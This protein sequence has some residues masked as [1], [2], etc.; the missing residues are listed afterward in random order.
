M[1]AENSI[2]SPPTY[3]IKC[4]N[5]IVSIR[6]TLDFHFIIWPLL[7]KCFGKHSYAQNQS[8]LLSLHTCVQSLG[9]VE[10]HHSAVTGSIVTLT[11]QS[12]I[13]NISL[14]LHE[15]KCLVTSDIKSFRTVTVNWEKLRVPSAIQILWS[16]QKQVDNDPHH[17]S[18]CCKGN[19]IHPTWPVQAWR[20]SEENLT[21]R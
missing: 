2:Q 19:A 14:L 15:Q 6:C 20:I 10:R 21:S 9:S 5:Y 7:Y 12:V 13:Q 18:Y 11:S 1:I 3:Y 16:V 4:Q 8:H 17:P